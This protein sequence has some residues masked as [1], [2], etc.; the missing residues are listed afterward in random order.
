MGVLYMTIQE[1]L[2]FMHSPPVVAWHEHIYGGG[3]SPKGLNETDH[4]YVDYTLQMMDLFG[5]DKIVTSLPIAGDQFCPPEDFIQVNN[6]IHKAVQRCPSRVHGLAFINPGFQKAALDELKRCVQELGFIGGKLLNQY[7]VNDP[8]LFPIIEKC[9]ELDIP[10]LMHA[11]H[12]TDPDTRCRQPR[13]SGGDHIA[14]LAKR[15]PEATLIMA[16]IGGGGD[17][18]WEIKAVADCPNVFADISGSIADRP[19]IE[20][21][22]RYLGADRLLFGTDCVWDCSVAKILGADISDEDKKTILAGAALQRF[23]DK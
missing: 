18:Q 11:G 5:I 10:I 6:H 4:A 23:F 22:V 3:G 20:E 9:I 14:D 21:S 19:L 1:Q 17:W 8:I 16:H 15:Y 13:I 7:F 12:V 2:Q